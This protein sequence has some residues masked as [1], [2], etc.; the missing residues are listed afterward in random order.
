MTVNLWDMTLAELKTFVKSQE[1]PDYR[2]KQIREWMYAGAESFD[3]MSNLPKSMRER[4]KETADIVLP[5]PLKVQTADDGTVKTLW[6]FA[7][8]NTVESVLMG[9]KHGDSACLSTQAGCKMNC[10]FCASAIGGFIR[11]LTMGEIMGQLLGLERATGRKPKRIV[12]MGMGEPLDNFDNVMKF[13]REVTSADGLNMSA[14]HISVS[15]CGLPDKILELAKSGLPVTLSLSLHA[16]DDKTRSELMPIN[17]KY[18]VDSVLKAAQ[19]FFEI[20]SRRVSYE[21]IMIDGVNDS[22][23]HAALLSNKLKGGHVNLI[24][25]NPVKGKSYKPSGNIRQFEE[26]LTKKGIAVTK[27]RKLG[28]GIDAACGQLKQSSIGKGAGL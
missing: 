27:R 26:Y 8:G 23:E 5:K 1:Y 4:L 10:A 3:T 20:T 19:S 18:G 11:N 14:R 6:E 28:R 12:L 22:I 16:P 24:E 25:Y 21:Y 9:Y 2:A 7:D 17:G 15:T 13:L